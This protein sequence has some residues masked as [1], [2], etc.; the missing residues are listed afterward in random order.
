MR[1][2]AAERGGE[3]Q[4]LHV[5]NP[6]SIKPSKHRRALH[7]KEILKSCTLPRKEKDRLG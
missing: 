6:H 3:G 4:A 2:L 1:I 5:Q 7:M